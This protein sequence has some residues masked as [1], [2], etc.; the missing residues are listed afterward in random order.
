MGSQTGGH[1]WGT[2]TFFFFSD[3]WGLEEIKKMNLSS[4]NEKKKKILHEEEA[5]VI[6]IWL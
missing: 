4:N 3:G 5:A 2:F 1:D 6:L